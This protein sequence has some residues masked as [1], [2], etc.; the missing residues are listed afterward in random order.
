MQEEECTEKPAKEEASQENILV[1]DA[2]A[3]TIERVAYTHTIRRLQC[4]PKHI[5]VFHVLVVLPTLRFGDP[6]TDGDLVAPTI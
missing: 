4:K 6:M 3:Q 5:E 2:V 1:L